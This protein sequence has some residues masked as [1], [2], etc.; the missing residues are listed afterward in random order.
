VTMITGHKI[1]PAKTAT[2]KSN[3][4]LTINNNHLSR[5]ISCS[6]IFAKF[7]SPTESAN[8]LA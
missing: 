4:R 2:R 3:K 6:N 5:A 8:A 1:K 7:L